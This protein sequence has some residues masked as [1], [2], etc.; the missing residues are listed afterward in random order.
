RE[1]FGAEFFVLADELVV[2]GDGGGRF[3]GEVQKRGR[4]VLSR[5]F[6]GAEVL[7][8]DEGTI[9]DEAKGVRLESDAFG[10]LLLHVEGGAKFPFGGKLQTDG[11]CGRIDGGRLGV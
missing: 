3:A 5:E 8:A 9:D 2:D 11:G 1:G 10:S 6:N 7:A 4:R